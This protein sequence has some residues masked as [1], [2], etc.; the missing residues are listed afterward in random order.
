MRNTNIIDDAK[1]NLIELSVAL[2][3]A[4]LADADRDDLAQV[5][6]LARRE[7]KDAISMLTSVLENSK[8]DV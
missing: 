6:C 2:D 3:L 7:I 1:E 5:I 4:L 8:H